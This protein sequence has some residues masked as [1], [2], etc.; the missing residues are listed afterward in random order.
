[1]RAI[2]RARLTTLRP[3]DTRDGWILS[4]AVFAVAL[5]LRLWRLGYPDKIIFDETYYAKDAYSLL[6]HGYELNAEGN[7]PAF[8]VHPPLGKWMI[9]VGQ[10]IFGNDSTGWR[11][12][13]AIV[14]SLCVL[15]LTR[16][17]RRMT[18]STLL[19]CIAGLLLTFDGLA[20]VLSRTAL[21]DGFLLFW[22]LVALLCIV[23]D[24][25][26]GRARLL[27]QLEAAPPEGTTWGKWGPTLG[28]RWWRL[29]SA[30]ALGAGCSTKWSCL[31]FIPAFVILMAMWDIGARR[32]ANLPRP[33]MSALMT[34][35]R[36]LVPTFAFIPVTVYVT[37]WT[38]WFLSNDAWDRHWRGYHGFIGSIR[39]FWHYHWEILNFHRNLHA[40]HNYASKPFTWLVI[41]R[42]VS[43][44]VDYPKN[45]E[46]LYGETCRHVADKCYSEV[47]AV[48]TPAIWWVGIPALLI[49]AFLWI[50]RRDWRAALALTGFVAGF[51]PWTFFGE[52]T[53]FYFYALPL[54]PFEIIAI[55]LVIGM[56]LGRDPLPDGSGAPVEVVERSRNRRVLGAI[57]VGGYLLLVLINFIWLHPILTGDLLSPGDWANRVSDW[58]PG[59]I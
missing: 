13:A 42:P 51:V 7:G 18:G 3:T 54:F 39:G 23:R 31:Y 4:L 9:A 34:D 21:L 36:W 44:S 56:V 17:V 38:G 15:L 35:W 48:G 22:V 29:G 52:R 26:Q 24:R 27:A 10:W 49:T 45:G 53:M 28:W 6:K 1:M 30:V 59:W 14:G 40:T 47:L 55:V 58:F 25:D 11:F 32:S 57:A 41:G 46:S 20:F 43:F 50:S 2:T 33:A 12:S 8:V 19:G 5:L 37:S 16:I